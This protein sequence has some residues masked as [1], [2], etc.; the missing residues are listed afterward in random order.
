MR[1]LIV[2]LLLSACSDSYNVSVDQY[3]DAMN[4]CSTIHAEVMRDGDSVCCTKNLMTCA[5]FPKKD[6]DKP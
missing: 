2:C 1:I 3:R 5:A 4:Q 6:K